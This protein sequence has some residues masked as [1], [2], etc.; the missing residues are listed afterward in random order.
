MVKTQKTLMLDEEVIEFLEKKAEEESR[1]F[2][3]VVNE[4]ILRELKGGKKRWE[5]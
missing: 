1:S 3:Y 4:I 2:S 5:K